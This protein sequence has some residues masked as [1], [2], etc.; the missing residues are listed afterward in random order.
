MP[1]DKG[2]RRTL[3]DIMKDAHDKSRRNYV[4]TQLVRG[5]LEGLSK[6]TIKE[7]SKLD[8]LDKAEVEHALSEGNK[9]K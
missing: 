9:K 1:K 7:L 8:A 6:T 3:K 4:N 5:G 2:P